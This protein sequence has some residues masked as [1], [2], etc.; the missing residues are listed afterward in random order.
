ME[1]SA[2]AA[3]ATI[4]VRNVPTP[5][6]SM[7]DPAGMFARYL[8]GIQPRQS[9]HRTCRHDR[10]PGNDAGTAP[11]VTLGRFPWFRQLG[12]PPSCTPPRESIQN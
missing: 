7:R 1:V 10:P 5:A 9:T 12:Q 8:P 6:A 2:G 3:Y 4:S 11:M